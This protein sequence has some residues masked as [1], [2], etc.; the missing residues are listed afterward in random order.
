MISC[1]DA[2]RVDSSIVAIVLAEQRAIFVWLGASI[3]VTVGLIT[4][5]NRCGAIPST[6]ISATIGVTVRR[7]AIVRSTHA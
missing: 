4:S 2:E 3:A 1:A 7:S 5:S 6:N